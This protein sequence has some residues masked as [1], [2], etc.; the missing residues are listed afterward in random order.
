[1]LMACYRPQLQLVPAIFFRV[2]Q[3][4]LTM[5]FIKR[6]LTQIDDQERILDWEKLAARKKKLRG[7]EGITKATMEKLRCYKCN[8][9]RLF[10]QSL[11][12]MTK[13]IRLH[14]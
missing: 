8:F 11:W 1:M 4:V 6:Y 5:V 9:A 13:T 2:K 14:I 7:G 10:F 12:V 3:L